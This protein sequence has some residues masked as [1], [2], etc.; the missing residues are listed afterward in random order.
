MSSMSK[1]HLSTILITKLAGAS[2]SYIYIN[3]YYENC[4]ML[5]YYAFI[6]LSFSISPSM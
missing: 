6:V 3:M 5:L 2:L 1:P 4:I